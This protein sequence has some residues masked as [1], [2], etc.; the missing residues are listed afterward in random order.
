MS[1]RAYQTIWALIVFAWITNY[2][3][4]MAP[5]ALWPPIMAE[6]GLDYTLTGFLSTAFFY[7]YMGMQFPAGFLGDRFGRKRMLVA[8]LVLG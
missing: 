8:G 1:T 5:N 3:I 7:A 6:L 4:R 2:L